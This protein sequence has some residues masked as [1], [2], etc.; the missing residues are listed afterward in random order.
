[1]QLQGGI[2][3]TVHAGP[4]A[5]AKA[6]LEDVPVPEQTYLHHRL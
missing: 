1:M 5:I 4:F 3:T 6:F 2:A